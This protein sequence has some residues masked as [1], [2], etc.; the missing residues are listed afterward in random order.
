MVKVG[1]ASAMVAPISTWSAVG[2]VSDVAGALMPSFTSALTITE[3]VL[4]VLQ[5]PLLPEHCALTWLAPTIELSATAAM[6]K[7]VAFMSKYS[8][9]VEGWR[10]G[11]SWN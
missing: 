8:E 10:D 4:M 9:K 11:C 5:L 3:A 2:D 6:R 1:P 7:R